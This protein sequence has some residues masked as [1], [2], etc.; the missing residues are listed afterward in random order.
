MDGILK[1]SENVDKRGSSTALAHS[2]SM[3]GDLYIHISVSL[4]ILPTTKGYEAKGN[5]NMGVASCRPPAG[6]SEEIRRCTARW[7]DISRAGVHTLKWV[8]KKDKREQFWPSS[9]RAIP[10][11][12]FHTTH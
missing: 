7:V 1:G 8:V 5:V 3:F 11:I 2:R 4:A 9:Q 10:S 6:Q 12:T